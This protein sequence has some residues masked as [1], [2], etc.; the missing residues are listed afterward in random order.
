M[1][2]TSTVRIIINPAAISMSVRFASIL[3]RRF[4]GLAGAAAVADMF[5]F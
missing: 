4:N 5:R 3:S 2:K 1:G